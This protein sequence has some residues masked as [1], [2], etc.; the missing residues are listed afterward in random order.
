M[1]NNHLITVMYTVPNLFFQIFLLEFLANVNVSSRSLYVVVRPS[2]VCLSVVSLSV[3]NV[4]APYSGDCNFLQYFYILRKTIYPSFPRRRMV[5]GG[6][7]FY[8]KF[9]VNPKG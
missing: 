3:C 4:R 2:V 5:S 9:W 7:P 6:D 8:L 1:N